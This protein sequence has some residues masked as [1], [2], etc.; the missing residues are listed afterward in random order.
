[1][2]V[3]FPRACAYRKF[4]SRHIDGA[5]RPRLGDKECARRDRRRARPAHLSPGID[6]CGPHC[7]TTFENAHRTV[8]REVLFGRF[9]IGIILGLVAEF[10]FIRPSTRLMMPSFAA[11]WMG[12]MQNAGWKFQHGCST[13]RHALTLSL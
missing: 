4:T 13:G 9:F 10:A 6:A 2:T 5:V 1:M 7:T 8:L 3:I 11:R 12:G